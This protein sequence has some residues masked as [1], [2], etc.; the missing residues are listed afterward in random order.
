MLVLL[1]FYYP[2]I[3]VLARRQLL[4]PILDV[5]LVDL[6]LREELILLATILALLDDFPLAVAPSLVGYAEAGGEVIEAHGAV[7]VFAGLDA[8]ALVIHCTQ[9]L[10]THVVVGT[11]DIARVDEGAGSLEYFALSVADRV[12]VA[13]HALADLLV[14]VE[15][16][17]VGLLSHARVA[18]LEV[19]EAVLDEPGYINLIFLYFILL[20]YA[21]EKYQ[22]P[23]QRLGRDILI[24]FIETYPLPRLYLILQLH[25]YSMLPHYTLNHHIVANERVIR[26]F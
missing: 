21:L 19:V 14:H 25:L 24:D 23:C 8:H 17:E 5:V 7:L 13:E 20:N 22:A 16:Q 15:E 4:A 6:G 10:L 18:V 26:D 11:L 1:L 12:E 2:L 3:A 9:C